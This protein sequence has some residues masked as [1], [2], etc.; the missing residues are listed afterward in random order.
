MCGRS[1]GEAGR[2]EPPRSV[3]SRLPWETGFHEDGEA[4][5]DRIAALAAEV[6][7]AEVAAPAI[8]ARGRFDP[9]HAPPRRRSASWPGLA[10]GRPSGLPRARGPS[11]YPIEFMAGTWIR[12]DVAVVSGDRSPGF[13]DPPGLTVLVA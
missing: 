9:R 6:P 10:P 3:L 11:E 4:I 7:P 1:P 5:A 12:W 8:D 13:S 2:G